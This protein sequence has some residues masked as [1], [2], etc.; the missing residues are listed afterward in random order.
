MIMM[1]KMRIY[2]TNKCH[3]FV[4]LIRFMKDDGDAYDDDDDIKKIPQNR[5][6]IEQTTQYLG[7]HLYQKDT[8]NSIRY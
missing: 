2:K 1:M 6:D 3:K 8:P 4:T 7:Y 5:P